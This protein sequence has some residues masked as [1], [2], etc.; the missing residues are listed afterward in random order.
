MLDI[1]DIL[2]LIPHRPPFVMI[3]RVIEFNPNGSIMCTKC[4]TIGEPF[5]QGH[6]PD[7]PVMPGVLIIE[8]MA[9]S[10]AVLYSL[11]N[12]NALEGKKA[13]FSGIDKAK[14]RKKVVPG[15]KLVYS[16][17]VL[18]KSSKMW[19]LKAVAKVDGKKV[20]EA[21]ISAILA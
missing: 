10:A 2:K 8:G 4:V 7:E 12:N 14:F 6:F 11:S 19:K 5:L 20:A 3:D 1:N 21:I 15:D 16:I 18:Q 9:Q 17:Q 13:Y